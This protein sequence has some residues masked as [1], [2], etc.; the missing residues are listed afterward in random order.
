MEDSET[1]GNGR[2]VRMKDPGSL[3]DPVEHSPKWLAVHWD[4]NE[5][6]TLV[7]PLRFGDR[8]EQKLTL[9]ESYRDDQGE[10][11]CWAQD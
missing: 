10:A 2:T 9:P 11:L 4:G 1:L 5:K 6:L 8:K 3:H 7:K